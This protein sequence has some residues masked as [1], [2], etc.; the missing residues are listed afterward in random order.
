VVEGNRIGSD[1]SGT[2]V[3]GNRAGLVLGGSNN[4]IGGTAAE[5][6]NLISGN[7]LDG[8]TIFGNDNQVQGNRIGT[9]AAGTQRLPNRGVG[10]TVAFGASQNTI[11]GTTDGAGNLI[12]GNVQDGVAIFGNDNQV[13]G[14]R[15]GTNVTGTGGLGNGSNGVSVASR[16]TGNTIGGTTAGAGNLLSGNSVDGAYGLALSGDGNVA[17]GNF[18]GTDVTGTRALSNSLSMDVDGSNNLIGGTTPEA[19]NL[20]AGSKYELRISGGN[21]V[22]QGNYIGTDITG[23]VALG[24]FNG[25]AAVIFGIDLQGSNN[26][27]GGTDA[28]AGNLIAGRQFDGINIAGHAN[29]VQGNTIGSDITG[30]RS[31]GN[32]VGVLVNSGSNN[33]IGGTDAAAAN[34]IVFNS[35]NGV[36]VYTGTGN[37]IRHN[38]IFASGSLGIRLANGGNHMQQFPDLT[39]ATSDGSVLTVAG[40]LQSTPNTTFDIELFANTVRNPTGFGEG[41]RFLAAFQVTTDDD[42]AASFEVTLDIDVPVGQFIAATATD[43][44]G[45]TSQFSR[46]V[47]VTAVGETGGE[48]TPVALVAQPV[49]SELS[50]ATS[51][52]LS[53]PPTGGVLPLALNSATYVT[54]AAGAATGRGVAVD[55]SGNEYVAGVIIQ[56]DGSKSAFVARYT[57]AGTQV[58]EHEFNFVDESGTAEP[59]EAHGIAVDDAGNLYGSANV[60]GSE[61]P[62]ASRLRA[63]LIND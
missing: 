27:I 25:T 56:T 47:T 55:A 43:P 23:T 52:I 61:L 44:R 3:L 46:S 35:Q 60:V 63:V 4:R 18:I 17:Q 37:A 21:N 54:G 53:G 39:S 28:G 26:L 20:I 58:Y 13:Q 29:L 6:G 7:R 5:A 12:S 16:A 11:G 41:E 34:T 62:R 32:E 48:I 49:Q 15:V 22:V 33:T 45:N 51:V 40:T 59:T 50:A 10:V 14:N 8:I 1:A 42:G 24:S 31:L 9:N 38:A 19:R 57:A 36:L 2:A 30:T